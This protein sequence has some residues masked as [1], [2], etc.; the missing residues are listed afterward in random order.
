MHELLYMHACFLARELTYK[1]LVLAIIQPQGQLTW[2]ML[3]INK[4][5]MMPPAHQQRCSLL[6]VV[7]LASAVDVIAVLPLRCIIG[8]ME[9]ADT[10]APS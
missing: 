1:F 8:L 3:Y 5:A 7:I 10:D 9:Q 6:S 2:R 4:L